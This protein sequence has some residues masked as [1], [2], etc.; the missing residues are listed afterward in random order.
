MDDEWPMSDVRIMWCGALS[1][2]DAVHSMAIAD[3][4]DKDLRISGTAQVTFVPRLHGWL[5]AVVWWS[6][7]AKKYETCMSV[8]G[9]SA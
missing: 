8:I 9:V 2:D 4:H 6:R 3:D 1:Q 5:H 7:P